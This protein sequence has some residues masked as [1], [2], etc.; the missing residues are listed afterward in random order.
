MRDAS[1][2]LVDVVGAEEPGKTAEQSREITRIGV[3]AQHRFTEVTTAGA[4]DLEYHMAG[5]IVDE[6]TT[7]GRSEGIEA[8][9]ITAH[10]VIRYRV[11]NRSPRTGEPVRKP[12][13]GRRG[14]YRAVILVRRTLSACG[15]KE[16]RRRYQTEPASTR[17][18]P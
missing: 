14:R 18:P 16:H 15:P 12:D 6:I 11:F 9:A 7:G 4:H 2:G 8:T 3:R 1:R 13:G 10:R 17:R 5:F